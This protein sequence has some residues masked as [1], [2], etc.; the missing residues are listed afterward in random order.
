MVLTPTP[1][2]D[3]HV[4]VAHHVFDQEIWHAVAK[5]RVA[6]LHVIALELAHI[7]AAFDPVG[8][9]AGIDRLP[10]H[11]DVQA[12]ELA[13]GIEA[14]RQLAL[15]D[16]A[17]KIVRLVLLAAPD[18]LDW[19]TGEFLGDRHRLMHVVLRAAAP[20]KAATEVVAVDFA[21][22]QRNAGGLRERRERRL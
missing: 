19:N 16:R 7:P 18:Q 21:V 20:A 11:A 15:R 6:R 1:C 9:E 5:L 14:R 22:R 13:V 3:R 2:A 17:V 8:T 4:G 10:G 12:R